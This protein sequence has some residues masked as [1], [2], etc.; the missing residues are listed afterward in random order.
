MANPADIAQGTNATPVNPTNWNLFV[1]RINELGNKVYDV[2]DYGAAGDGVTDDTTAIQAAIDA[3]EAASG[4]VVFFPLGKYMI[5]AVLTVTESNIELIGVGPASSIFLKASTADHMLFI[6]ST[7][8]DIEHIRVAD[9]KFDGNSDNQVAST[10]SVI[11]IGTHATYAANDVVIERVYMVDHQGYGVKVGSYNTSAE[12]FRVQV[13]DCYFENTHKTPIMAGYKSTDMV[14][15][16]NRIKSTVSTTAGSAIYVS[17]QSHRCLIE[18]NVIGPDVANFGI[19]LFGSGGG[20]RGNVN[21]EGTIAN[22]VISGLSAVA[23]VGTGISMDASDDVICIGNTITGGGTGIENAGGT[24]VIISGNIIRDGAGDAAISCNHAA[25]VS[26]VIA[27]SIYNSGYI[28]IQD[29]T[30]GGSSVV[31][32]YLYDSGHTDADAKR[33]INTDVPNT[34]IAS[35]HLHFSASA[36]P[37]V[38]PLYLNTTGCHCYGNT[39]IEAAA[40]KITGDFINNLST[41]FVYNNMAYD[42]DASAWTNV[43]GES[44]TM[45]EN[46]SDGDTTPSVAAGSLFKTANT[47][48]TT[49]TML[50]DGIVGKIVRVIFGDGN[51]TVDFT[52]TNLKTNSSSDW[53][54]VANDS[55]ICVFDGTDWYCDISGYKVDQDMETTDAVI[56][57]GVTLGNEGL[58]ILDTNAS[59]DLIV[60][61]GSDLTA[62]RILTLATGDA[63][64]TITL[65]GDPTLSDWFDQSV[66]QAATPA[67]SSIILGAATTKT[68]SF[69]GFTAAESKTLNI[70]G[71]SGDNPVIRRVSLWISNDPTADENINCR[72]S[73][74]NSDSMTEDELLND[75]FFNLTYTEINNGAGYGA[76]DTAIT[77]DDTS[78]IVKYDLV[79]FLDGTPENQRNTAVPTATVLTVTPLVGSHADNS[80]VVRVA[81]ITE[82]FQLLDSDASNEIHCKLEFLSAP[83]AATN[84]AI[85]IEVQ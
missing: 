16:G 8:A 64:R 19:V 28:N 38:N 33:P 3:A 37:V 22:N 66:K 24:R 36:T 39:I 47:G 25:Q 31:G 77:V 7:T 43:G 54:P 12:C 80:G 14:V 56:L 65:S 26:L 2:K 84:V 82:M 34:L 81:E 21:N 13:R 44:A 50:D 35:N 62:D 79:R 29:G 76:T 32:N 9:L 71:V 55:M 46:F 60:K 30:S 6:K 41:N 85:S 72:L 83:T 53:S 57:A 73:F 15:S 5:S 61:A 74:Y 58:H 48:A 68:G 1:D 45:L 52:G 70:T 75:F 27:N 23:G 69:T 10:K 17:N 78:G 42:T 59:H 11:V 20:H 51:T 4:G 49:I 63:A 18:G 40:G 67:F